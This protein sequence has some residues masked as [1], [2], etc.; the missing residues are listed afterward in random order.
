M[1]FSSFDTIRFDLDKKVIKKTLGFVGKKQ[2]TQ[3]MECQMTLI[4]ISA[5]LVDN[6][7]ENG[8]IYRWPIFYMTANLD[9]YRIESF[10]NRIDIK[11]NRKVFA[12]S[13]S[14]IESNRNQF[15]LTALASA[16]NRA[17]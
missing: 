5:I 17:L 3:E 11:P 9:M 10:L 1:T 2:K 6:P 7:F 15:D 12:T 14:K 13:R 8:P 4:D 16:V